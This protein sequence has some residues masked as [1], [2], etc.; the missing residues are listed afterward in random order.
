LSELDLAKE[1]LI[2]EKSEPKEKKE[3]LRGVPVVTLGGG[4]KAMRAGGFKLTWAMLC[5]PN[6]FLRMSGRFYAWQGDPKRLEKGPLATGETDMIGDGQRV[7]GR[8]WQ[9]NF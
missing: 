6:F 2:Q 3:K 8:I 5:K 4:K 1:I 7:H 9:S